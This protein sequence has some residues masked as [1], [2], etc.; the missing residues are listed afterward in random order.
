M[1][2]ASKSRQCIHEHCE[3]Y[4]RGAVDPASMLAR[5]CEFY[6]VSLA[7]KL[8][9]RCEDAIERPLCLNEAQCRILAVAMGQAAMGRPIRMR[10]GK[11]RKLGSS[12]FIQCLAVFLGATF[13]NQIAKT[14]GHT[15]RATEEIFDIA[16]RAAL[17]YSWLPINPD[18]LSELKWPAT[19]S[20]YFCLT[21][22]GVAVGA[23]GTPSF[24][25]MS[26]KSKWERN[27]EETD[28]NAT[29]SVPDHPLTC[30]FD[31]STFKGRDLFYQQF[32]A[33]LA[34]STDYAALFLPWYL[35]DRLRKE[36]PLPFTPD[37]Y[38]EDL[39]RRAQADGIELPIE[40]LQ[41]R[42]EKISEAE[43]GLAIFRQEYPSTVEEALQAATGIILPGMRSRIIDTLPFEIGNIPAEQ[44]VGGIDFGYHDPCVIWSAFHIDDCC[45]VY[46][47]W[48]RAESL[49][50]DQVDG[51]VENTTY[52]C[53]PAQVSD[54]K[55]LESESR[56]RGLHCRFWPAPRVKFPGEQFV[57]TELQRLIRFAEQGR[58]FIMRNVAKQLI[59]ETDTYAW[60]EQ[61][62]KPDDRR[63]E[64]CGHYDS[65]D[66]L[67][68]MVMGVTTRQL[69]SYKDRPAVFNRA[70][71]FAGF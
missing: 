32:E 54:R 25:H 39:L 70:K 23:G 40:A 65:I 24:L 47:F 59:V 43:I 12:T 60:N 37:S 36:A 50:T 64:M 18:C 31:E 11:S 29:I 15:S 44:K 53:D 2:G 14:I 51:L 49:A 26:E 8:L 35:D 17:S 30:I 28:Y 69:P 63:S 57:T 46:S 4:A 19:G 20:K 22:G 67:R 13:G 42:R 10:L 55:N 33:A 16:R 34:D 9:I 58:L 3:A 27:K 61:T 68:Y 6:V 7:G 48:R 62:G 1:A 5:L 56:K 21:A 41:W 45:Y 38:E 71:E 66:A 52:Y